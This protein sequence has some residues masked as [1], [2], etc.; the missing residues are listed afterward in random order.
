MSDP[1]TITCSVLLALVLAAG[2]RGYLKSGKLDAMYGDMWQDS[3]LHLIDLGI[4]AA[5][6]YEEGI[7]FRVRGR[8]CDL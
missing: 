3:M 6:S 4:V 8:R 7:R 5:G 1:D 2:G